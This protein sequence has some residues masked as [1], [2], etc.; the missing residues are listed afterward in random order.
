[1]DEVS[2]WG[3]FA[4]MWMAAAGISLLYVFFRQY[5]ARARYVYVFLLGCW[6][7]LWG[8]NRLRGETVTPGWLL[9][10]LFLLGIAAMLRDSISRYRAASAEQ[11]A[12]R[13]AR[14]QAPPH[15]SEDGDTDADSPGSA[16]FP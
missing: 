16:E 12:E 15:A 8:I 14:I 4:G 2:N 5:R 6:A 1:V 9:W 10:L 13:L 3:K 11:H 7:G